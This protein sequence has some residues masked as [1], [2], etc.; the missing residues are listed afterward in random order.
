VAH[1]GAGAIR[2]C[3]RRAGD[4]VQFTL[5]GDVT[6][7][8]DGHLLQFGG[9][10]R[11]VLAV[12]LFQPN[13][14]VRS[15]EIV[16]L[17]WGDQPGSPPQASNGR[18]ADYISRLRTAFRKVGAD[19][20]VALVSRPP[21]Y[22]LR[23][24]KENIDWHR[25]RRLV[26]SARRARDAVELGEAARLLRDA[27]D[28][29][30]GPPLAD[31]GPTLD[32]IRRQLDDGRLA[33]AEDLAEIELAR[34]RADRVVGLLIELTMQHPLRERLVALLIRAL[35][36]AGRRDEAV[37]AY[38]R[39]RSQLVDR[40][41]LDPAD[42]IQHAYQALLTDQPPSVQPAQPAGPRQLP[43]DTANFVGR[44]A[45]LATLLELAAAPT[46]PGSTDP[47]RTDP[48]A[49]HRP[50][51]PGGT[52]SPNGSAGAPAT[53]ALASGLP[54]T[55][56]PA[57][58]TPATGTPATG[59]PAAG[60]PAA[61]VGVICVVD[62][63]AGVGKTAFAV[64]A[65]H[66]LAHR[67]PDG[68]LFLDLH[69]YTANAP[70]V[71]PAE[72]LARLLR[73]LGV[74]GETIPQHLDD[75]AALYRDR[76]AQRRTLILLDNAYSADQVR[77]LLPAAAGC[78]VLVTSRRRLTA[79]DD[80]HPLSLET[81]PAVAAITLFGR[82]AG[83]D[84]LRGQHAEVE[85]IAD[86]CGGLPLAIRIAAARLRNHPAWEPRYL[87]D[88]LSE[89]ADPP[90]ELDDGERSIAAAFTLSYRGLTDTHQRMFRLLGLVPGSDVDAYA[91][92]ALIDA[93]VG[94]A[95]RLLQDMLDAH[96]LGQQVADRYRFHDLM[97]LFAARLAAAEDAEPDRRAALARL[98]SH[99]LHTA[100]AAMDVLFPHER[101]R[102]PEVETPGTPGRDV[103]APPAAR[104]WLDA[105]RPN[106]IAAATFA[107]E[108][109]WPEHTWQL[110][111][112]LF[113]Y[114]VNGAHYADALQLNRQALRAVRSRPG[115]AGE[116]TALD[117]LGN[118]YRRLG[119]FEE[120]L[121]HLRRALA[122]HRAAGDALE[123]AVTL[124]NLGLL[125]GLQGRYDEALD[126]LH[127][128][129]LLDRQVGNRAN[130]A[131][132]L[133]NL[134]NL[135]QFSGD[136]SAALDC[137]RQAL[138]ISADIGDRAGEGTALANLGNIQLRG[139]N[140]D[141]AADHYERALQIFA[142][143]G[144]RAGQGSALTNLGE[145]QE[146][147]GRYDLAVEQLQRA[148]T[149]YQEI[150]HLPNQ[151]E[152]LSLLASCS[153]ALQR[154]DESVEQL[155]R[156]LRIARGI[157]DH[158]IEAA[159]VNRLGRTLRASGQPEQ[160]M[161]AHRA[162]LALARR[163]G[164]RYEQAGALEGIAELLAAAGS[165]RAAQRHWRA[166]LDIHSD[167]GTAEAQR[168]Q[169]PP[170]PPPGAAGLPE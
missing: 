76:L 26:D 34:G 154:Y 66:L 70:Q 102:R 17:V 162:A 54:A 22:L 40:L 169:P 32:P 67:F 152:T 1:G 103:A 47:A 27:L 145:V 49:S 101:G 128:A 140:Y 96:L 77:P 3:R 75:R 122:A 41:G 161:A 113:R 11:S 126:H 72:A 155:E 71:E 98:F 104:A 44:T 133:A 112:I 9:R 123:E 105:E 80:A 93:S 7:D 143:I 69:G 64:H 73:S 100:A 20:E 110:G 62:G 2:S 24:D 151:G 42:A 23:V 14:V 138:Q 10:Q 56:E 153:A 127:R 79:L 6:A 18:V 158:T 116:G 86:L 83:P 144:D 19:Q 87:A 134:G 118:T 29:W 160:A 50:L 4:D 95:E 131:N 91:A 38:H 65:A 12:L 37:T 117:H 61:G 8:R 106:L 141:Q 46:A 99:Q 147:R 31:V 53:G 78:L 35:H 111:A 132:T 125:L 48:A 59:E 25:F 51:E 168:I 120:A 84:R 115:H 167:L 45:E 63:M 88:R 55:G 156:A 28:L 94:Q 39:S 60:T 82:V 33:A 165:R 107:V 97:R 119:R 139:G 30:R 114:L 85:R 166:A 74:A 149:I 164:N 159:I 89:A 170:L 21:G 43:L 130:L 13:T 68:Q 142:D 58:A 36:A 124:T 121:D 15:T 163:L 148:L 129:L 81:L 52:A 146:R 5:L 57:T 92:A 150:G 109:G 157:G 90:V 135:H 137:Y 136:Y 16:R 108:H